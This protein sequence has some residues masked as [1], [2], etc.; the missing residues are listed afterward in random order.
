MADWT[1]PEGYEL[2]FYLILV[3]LGVK[4]IIS[5][6]IGS[7]IKI[8]RANEEKVPLALF[9]AS[10]FV[11]ITMFTSQLCWLVGDYVFTRFEILLYT[12]YPAIQLLK[13]GDVLNMMGITALMFVIERVVLL[14]RTRYSFTVILLII[15]FIIFLFPVRPGN[16]EDFAVY[17][18]IG[19]I[20]I[21]PALFGPLVFIWLG[22]VTPK[23]RRLIWTFGFGYI[24]YQLA[25]VLVTSPIIDILS[26]VISRDLIYTICASITIIGM[27]CI[28]YGTLKFRL[29]NKAAL[30]YYRSRKICIVHRGKIQGT[31]FM[32][33]ACGV[34]Y[35][36]KC[37]DAAVRAENKCWNCKVMLDTSTQISF[38]VRAD[39]AM[40]QKFANFK[41]ELSKETDIEAFRT[42]LELGDLILEE[43]KSQDFGD[44]ACRVEEII[45]KQPRDE[46]NGM[47]ND[48]I[49]EHE[50]PV[51]ERES[52]PKNA[53]I[54]K[55]C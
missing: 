29:I 32:C 18:T 17:S 10:F 25:F 36:G 44:I 41:D 16:A 51:T 23:L 46:I 48:S 31:P 14:K 9:Y 55:I 20:P 39:D 42:L 35:C 21:L 33:A 26:A 4:A 1:I 7:R 40:F 27:L 28:F 19:M 6:Y 50:I 52:S 47:I 11:C 37:K 34:L 38:Q 54:D 43:R 30:D 8:E 45:T 12:Y 3:Q 5:M 2:A 15:T 53:K 22:I 13:S 24:I 49:A